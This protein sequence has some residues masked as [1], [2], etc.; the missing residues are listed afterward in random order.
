MH[1]IR[2]QYI[3]NHVHTVLAL[4]IWSDSQLLNVVQGLVVKKQF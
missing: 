2:V 1:A 3:K 4:K